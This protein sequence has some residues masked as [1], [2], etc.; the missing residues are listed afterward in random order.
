VGAGTVRNTLTLEAGVTPPLVRSG[1]INLDGTLINR[2]TNLRFEAG[3]KAVTQS[4]ASSDA[5]GST[6]FFT[7]SLAEGSFGGTGTL[8]NEGTLAV[9]LSGLRG[10][11]YDYFGIST[12]EFSGLNWTPGIENLGTATLGG[13]SAVGP[14]FDTLTSGGTFTGPITNSGNL[15]FFGQIG[16]STLTQTAGTTTLL[17]GPSVVGGSW[18]VGTGSTMTAPNGAYLAVNLTNSGALDF[19][20]GTTVGTL[21]NQA[22][23]TV[24]V[25]GMLATQPTFLT[26]NAGTLILDG[27]T[28]GL[29]NIGT[30]VINGRFQPGDPLALGSIAGGT[31]ELR[32]GANV[33]LD[34][35]IGAAANVV[36]GSGS[37]LLFTGGTLNGPGA[38]SILSSAV[39]NQTGGSLNRDVS[40]GGTFNWSGGSW[41]SGGTTTIGSGGTLVMNG[42]GSHDFI[43]RPIVN[44]GTVNWTGGALQ[45]GAG[46]SFT[47]NGMFNDAASAV[48]NT[49]GFYGG[50]FS[51]T[52]TGTYNKTA[53]GTT[54]VEIPF[55]NSG[56]MNVQAGTLRLAGGGS[57]SAAGALS[58][59]AGATLAFASDYTIPDASRLSG[60]GTFLFTQMLNLSGNVNLPGFQM[61][62]GKLAGSQTFN[63][64]VIWNGADLSTGGT[65]T[66]GAT[67][68][69]TMSGSNSHDF[70]FRTIVNNGTVN[71]TGGA[72][73]SGAGGGFT[74][75]GTL[76]DSAS[77]SFFTA[78]F[79][80]GPF[81]FTNT[82]T[83]NKTA[84]GTTTVE[85]PFTNT[86]TVNVQAGTLRLAGGGSLSGAGALSVA[87]GA[88]L[89]F[90]SDHT[91]GDAARLGGAGHFLLSA[92]TLSLSGT[93]ATPHFQQTGGR[94]AGTYTLAGT[95]DMNS[96]D[97]NFGGTTTIANS[98]VLNV[99]V[100]LDFLSR[101]IVT[102]GTVNWSGGNLQS[103]LGGSITNHG[104][105]NDAASASMF[106]SGYYGGA[107][108]FTNTG[109]YNKTAAGTTDIQIPFT[110]TGVVSVQAG[111]LNAGGVV[112][113]GVLPGGTWR[114]ADGARLALD[115]D[116]AV[117]RNA[118]TVVLTGA[119]SLFNGLNSLTNNSGSLSLL[120]GRTFNTS[121][122]FINSGTLLIGSG[123]SF[124]TSGT[125]TNSGTLNVLGAFAAGGGLTNLGT[126]AGAGAI[127][128]S[129][130][131][132]GTLA[133]GNSPGLL[134]VTGNLTLLSTS[135]LVMELGGMVEGV[136]YD[137]IDV[138]GA[139]TLAGGLNVVLVNGFSPVSGASF[140]LIDAASFGG[141]FA[142]V[143]LPSLPGGLTWNTAAL[144]T[145][146][147]IS[148]SGS[149]IPEPST[150]AAWAGALALAMGVWVR[151]RARV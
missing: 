137:S 108:T 12:S 107:F 19:G 89:A 132:G 53:P 59:A 54:T 128:G 32:N 140:N 46:G 124:A 47:N 117:A 27:A 109:T 72:L 21:Q 49:H 94:L 90:A 30:T 37:A 92:G 22:G 142:S 16:L 36:V 55:T 139:I 102:S 50:P 141:N 6:R 44:N 41:S 43:F 115:G 78:G 23:G 74:N 42:S 69:L 112:S 34:N 8:R 61:T 9:D 56:T 111:Q 13:N 38:L 116:T 52:N 7:A 48:I 18:S 151:R 2:T 138:T 110:N 45:S 67:G 57:F 146:G 86:G 4:V 125:F 62:A 82:G 58:V 88:T 148:V 11:T 20:A 60:G 79:Y 136:S 133:P 97:W 98:G 104:T 85:I 51:F 25:A 35:G 66:I 15:T 65:T 3:F 113:G 28:A 118:A 91:I 26:G 14:S 81:S 120:G 134:T 17:N 150:Y 29:R 83:Y 24:R 73:Q 64:A 105:F 123:S 144:A 68:T 10:R 100:G 143:N 93:L 121:A 135:Q 101:A 119:N 1:D 63:N 149:A 39:V 70:I 77:A 106:A 71:W 76:N 75:N 127:T 95:Y 122:A 130:T 84:P 99:T 33:T 114:V 80:G 131:S 126:L 87:A 5:G 147:L 129:L 103:G 145:A 31:L 40:I 96:T